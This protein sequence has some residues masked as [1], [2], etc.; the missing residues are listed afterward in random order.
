MDIK[1]IAELLHNNDKTIYSMLYH[2][3]LKLPYYKIG[4]KI[5]V[6]TEDVASYINTKKQN[7]K[8]N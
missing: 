8:G 4:R 3:R 6:D 7:G 1:A 5:F 2:G